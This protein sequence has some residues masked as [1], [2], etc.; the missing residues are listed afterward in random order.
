MVG[1]GRWN[2]E[3]YVGEELMVMC[4]CEWERRVCGGKC[5]RGLMVKKSV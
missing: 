3:K 5:V 1:G 4:M 2:W